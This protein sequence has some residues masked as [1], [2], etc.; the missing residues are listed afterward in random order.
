MGPQWLRTALVSAVA[1]IQFRVVLVASVVKVPPK[2]FAECLRDTH[3][4]FMPSRSGSSGVGDCMI[5]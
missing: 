2:L 5:R 1:V 4:R 3:E